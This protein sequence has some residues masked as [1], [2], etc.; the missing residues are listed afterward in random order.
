[1]AVM[2]AICDVSHFGREVK[3]K[4]TR[5]GRSMRELCEKAGVSRSTWYKVED[6][7]GRVNYETL[8]AIAECMDIY[9]VPIPDLEVTHP[10]WIV[11]EGK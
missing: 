5:W 8:R 1:M 7:D 11:E 6:G 2:T 4:R 9:L 3:K 10:A